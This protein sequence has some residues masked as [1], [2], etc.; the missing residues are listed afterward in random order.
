MLDQSIETSRPEVL[1][2]GA[3]KA[4]VISEPEQDIC[5]WISVL[6]DDCN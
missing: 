2:P 4:M 3:I 1:L 5:Y 6:E